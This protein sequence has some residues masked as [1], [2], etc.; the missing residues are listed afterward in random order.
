MTVSIL[1][2]QIRQQTKNFNCDYIEMFAFLTVSF[3]IFIP[4]FSLENIAVPY[5]TVNCFE[6]AVAVKEERRQQDRGLQL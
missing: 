6:L 5:S 1:L 2:L 3:S 4:L